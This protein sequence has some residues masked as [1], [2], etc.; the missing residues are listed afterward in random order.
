MAGTL[1]VNQEAGLGHD[2]GKGLELTL[3]SVMTQESWK[4]NPCKQ[5][6]VECVRPQV[7]DLWNLRV[8]LNGL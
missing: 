1:E 2:K 8:G 4:C 3:E 6:G 7:S 5:R